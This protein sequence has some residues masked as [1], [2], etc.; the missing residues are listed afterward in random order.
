MGRHLAAIT[1]FNI[2]DTFS[3][4]DYINVMYYNVTTNYTIPCFENMLVQATKENI[5]LFKKAIE[6][7]KPAGKTKLSQA[8]ET[9]FDLLSNVSIW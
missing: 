3:N 2:L 8:L 6:K 5:F 9:A 4:N 1:A 7:L